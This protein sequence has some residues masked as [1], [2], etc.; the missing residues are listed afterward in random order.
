M[1]SILS[2]SKSHHTNIHVSHTTSY[3]RYDSF[4]FFFILMHSNPHTC[5][6]FVSHISCS[7]ISAHKLSYAS[8]LFRLSMAYLYLY[9]KQSFLHSPPLRTHT[10]HAYK[11][12]TDRCSVSFPLVGK[13]NTLIHSIADV[14]IKPFDSFVPL[15]ML[16]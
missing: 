15:S 7:T 16:A 4:R 12:L 11:V 2:F 6:T 14:G 9:T 5:R 10:Y 13:T 8:S 1:F 3:T